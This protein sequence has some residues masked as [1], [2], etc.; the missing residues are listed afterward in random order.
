VSLGR[1]RA[2]AGGQWFLTPGVGAQGGDL[3]AALSAGLRSDGLGM[4]I[5]VSRGISRAESPQ[6]AAEQFRDDINAAREMHRLAAAP[7]SAPVTESGLESYQTRFIQ[8]ALKVRLR[9]CEAHAQCDKAHGLA[10]LVASLPLP[11]APT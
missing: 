3:E 9:R 10:F 1:V 11:C 4:L 5:A 6:K 7:P 2:A 8:D